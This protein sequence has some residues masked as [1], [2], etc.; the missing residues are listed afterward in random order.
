MFGASESL[1]ATD[2]HQFKDYTKHETSAF[3]VAGR[4]EEETSRGIST[5]LQTGI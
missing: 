2:L 4:P 3:D 1:F 5:R